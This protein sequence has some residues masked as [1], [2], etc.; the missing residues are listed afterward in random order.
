MDRSNQKGFSLI[1]IM[2]TVAIIGI[3]A[4][5]AVPQ[6]GQFKRKAIQANAKT[7]LSGIYGAQMTF[8]T[9]WDVG[10]P[11][12]RQMGYSQIGD[13]YYMAGWHIR[14]KVAVGINVNVTARS[15]V[16]GGGYDGPLATDI[17]EVNTLEMNF[18]FAP[19]VLSFHPNDSMTPRMKITGTC[20]CPDCGTGVTCTFD[21][22]V[23]GQCNKTPPGGTGNCGYSPNG[24]NNRGSEVIFNINAAGNIGGKRIDQWLINSN[25][26]LTHYIN[27]G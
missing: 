6:Y 27:G 15:Q 1:E 17:D 4:V 21:N 12:L 20:A 19:G 25:K 18:D 10:T 7:I 23:R 24:V 14:D 5:I 13:A 11:N 9:E 22:I 3:L 16:S 26:K 2:V 8:I